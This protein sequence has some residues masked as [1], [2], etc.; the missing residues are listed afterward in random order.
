MVTRVSPASIG[1]AA[2]SDAASVA[3]RI[4]GSG[5]GRPLLLMVRCLI[6][7]GLPKASAISLARAL[8]AVMAS[9][10]ASFSDF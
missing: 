7:K 8:K 2:A 10:V 6:R 9:S 5:G 1:I 3:A 4:I